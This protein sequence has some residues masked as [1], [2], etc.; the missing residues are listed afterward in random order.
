M[1]TKLLVKGGI[2]VAGCALAGL[3][4]V[5]AFWHGAA[6]DRTCASCHEIE[7]AHEMWTQSPH[8]EIGCAE[9]HGTVLRSG[10]HSL[11]EQGQTVLAHFGRPPD[12]DIRLQEEA[13]IAVMAAC[14]ACHAREYADWLSGGHSSTYADIF[15]DEEHNHN[16]RLSESC[17]RCHGMFFDGTIS[18]AVTPMNVSGPWQL[19]DPAIASVPTIPCLA[20]HHIHAE[21]LPA[22]RPDYS[23]PTTIAANREPRTAT[24]GFYDRYERVYLEAT[25]LPTLHVSHGETAVQAATDVRQRVCVQC[26]A[27]NAFRQAGSGD[28]RTPR[29]VHEGLSC[30][31]CHAAHSN[32]ASGSCAHCHPQLSNCGLP[33]DTMDTSFRDPAST[34]NIHF[35]ACTDCHDRGFLREKAGRG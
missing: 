1:A 7:S 5:Y 30:S 12:E 8:R 21:G 35:V 10:L 16:E 32:D 24:V 11:I 6:P 4:G 22:V 31:A 9:C 23:D 19:V 29:G 17:L 2:V 25:A 15:L 27:P 33:V 26:H 20:C 14:R 18:E 13:V 34:N 28:D 3:A